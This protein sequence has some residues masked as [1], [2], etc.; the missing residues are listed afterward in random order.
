MLSRREKLAM[1]ELELAGE[2]QSL[3][4][5][6]ALA[7]RER[8][9]L[10]A[11]SERTVRE[12]VLLLSGSGTP[13]LKL[14]YLVS[15]ATWTPSYA[16]RSTATNTSGV[17][18][19]YFAAVEQMSGEDWSGVSMTLSTATP[20][21]VAKAP[22]LLPLTL[23]LSAEMAEPAAQQLQLG[24]TATRKVLADNQ[25]RLENR[26]A[27]TATVDAD[28]DDKSPLVGAIVFD[29]EINDNAASIQILDL[30]SNEKLEKGKAVGGG[31]AQAANEEGLSVTYAI[32]GAASLPSRADRQLIQIASMPL[33]ATFAKV[34]TPVLTSF[35]YNEASVTNSSP[36]VL[37]SGPVT[38]YVD[39]AFVGGSALPTIASGESFV[40]GFGIDS[41]LRVSRE[42]LARAES[43]QGG[44]RVVELTY[45]LAVENFSGTPASVRLFDRLPQAKDGQVRIT[46]L[47]IPA[48]STDTDYVSTQRKAG[49]LRWDVSIPGDTRGPNA[50]SLEFSFKLEYDKQMNL[51]GI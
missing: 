35:V 28:R 51:T 23:A 11:D 2:A 41:S 29:R 47:T 1:E 30:V 24:Y 9:L 20:S 16:V 45:K 14:R 8:Q 48:T 38:A 6:L 15:N 49:I 17:S 27:Q 40:V 18:L 12:A 34:A 22:S 44:N 32:T 19:D 5:E 31:I 21:L 33:A 7:T 50:H 37:L 26:R 46:P 39:G 43:I 13:E 36:M 3:A 10:T 4:G 25:V 42:L